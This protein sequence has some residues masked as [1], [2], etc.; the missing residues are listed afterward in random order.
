MLE[1]HCRL[2]VWIRAAWHTVAKAAL[3]NVLGRF[4][5]KTEQFKTFCELLPESQDQNPALTFLYV[6]YLLDCDYERGRIKFS[7]PYLSLCLKGRIRSKQTLIQ[8]QNVRK[9]RIIGYDV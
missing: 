6:P 1:L 7:G 3:V 5:A 2:S 9:K 8:G 4:R